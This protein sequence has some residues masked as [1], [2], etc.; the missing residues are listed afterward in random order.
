MS[1]L[2]L[3]PPKVGF[4]VATRAA[5][6]LGIGLLVSRKLSESRRRALG[7]SLVT[8]GAVTTIPALL[9]LRQSRRPAGTVARSR[10]GI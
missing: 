9:L 10:S 4:I 7:T 6:A 3:S 1:D 2:V 5:L 8:L